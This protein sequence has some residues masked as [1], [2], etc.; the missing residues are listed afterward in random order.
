MQILR[1]LSQA[2]V[3]R[4]PM[5]ATV[6][7]ALTLMGGSVAF[8]ETKAGGTPVDVELVLAADGSGSIDDNELRLQRQGYAKAITHPLVLNAIRG[9][10]HQRI[11]VLF[12]EWGAPS[13]VEIIVGW[14][15]IRDAASA[16]VFADKLV[17]A[18]RKVFGYN[19]ISAAIQKAAAEIKGN[20][21][22]GLRKVIDV[23]GDGPQINGP[24][25]AEVRA[26]AIK[27]GIT[28]NGLVIAARGGRYS[29]PASSG[30]VAH[31]NRDV[32]G[33][34]GAFVM[35]ADEKTPFWEVV[36]RKLVREVAGKPA[37]SRRASRADGR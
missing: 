8:A 32:I 12:I 20:A 16:K 10:R 19:S 1:T 14:H 26:A 7:A 29:G 18:P 30:L 9:G 13:S 27:A 4:R 31:Y 35:V 22:A 6:A 34:P 37:D 15:V 28:I 25:L 36:L 24:P 5:T 2:A 21:Y 17:V 3:R 33:G 23:S 11:A